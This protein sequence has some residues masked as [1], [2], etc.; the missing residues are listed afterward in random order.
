MKPQ[1]SVLMPVYNCEN[2]VAESVASILNQSFKNLELIVIDGGSTDLT[3]E[4]I[5]KFKDKRLR[6]IAHQKRF[7]LVESRNEGLSLAR[8][9]LIALQDADDISHRQRIAK[10]YAYFAADNDLAVLGT[11]YAR[12]DPKRRIFSEVITHTQVSFMDFKKGMPMCNGSVMFRQNILLKEGFFDPLFRQCEDY[13]FYCRLGQKGYKIMNLKEPLYFL[14]EH[15]DRLSVSKWQEQ[16]LYLLLIRDLYFGDLE[17]RQIQAPEKIDLA[18]FYSLLSLETKRDYHTY[19]I[20]YYVK[21]RAYLRCIY[22]LL[23]LTKLSPKWLAKL[24]GKRILHP[25]SVAKA[26]NLIVKSES[27]W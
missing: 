10:Q 24:L 17:K 15:P 23:R 19:A 1:V 27:A 8:G 5:K 20:V 7:G 22:E 2:Y 11:S 4:V 9:N 3:L 12:I 14:R 25:H 21:S 16:T 18:Y 13:E 6:I 26:I